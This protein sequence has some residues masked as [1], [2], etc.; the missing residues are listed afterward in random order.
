[1]I[2]KIFD[3]YYLIL[4][5]GLENI[6]G[7]GRFFYFNITDI[8]AL[9]LT[10]NT[11]SLLILLMRGVLERHYLWF[12]IAFGVLWYVTMTVLDVIYNKKRREKLREEY[13]DESD[14]SRRRGVAWVVAYEV[15][16]VA[17]LVFAIW[18]TAHFRI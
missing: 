14:E 15:F 5:R 10:L 9:S 3:R 13:E 1:M 8:I 17:L 2:K 7:E 4:M 12:L 6:Y 11:A 16:T 18:I